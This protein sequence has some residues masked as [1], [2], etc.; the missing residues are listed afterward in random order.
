MYSKEKKIDKDVIKHVLLQHQPRVI[1]SVDDED[2]QRI[3]IRR[4]RLFS[5]ALRQFSRLSFDVSK[6]LQVRF[7]GEEAVDEG[8]P[9]REFFHLLMTEIFKSS[10]FSGF[11]SHVIPRHNIQAVAENTFYYVGKMISTCIVQ[12]GEV[13]SCFS[14]ACA[15][16]VVHGRVCSPVCVQDIPEEEVKECLEKVCYYFVV[17]C[18]CVYIIAF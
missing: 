13:P 6:M 4:S 11:P 15:D 8:G 1:Q 3:H 7:V 18:I 12:G 14:K 16:Y 5:D 9:R 10:L 17:E 2:V